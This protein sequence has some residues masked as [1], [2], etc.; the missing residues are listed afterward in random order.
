MH[1][2]ESDMIE[3]QLF[4]D[5]ETPTLGLLISK[6][7]DHAPVEVTAVFDSGLAKIITVPA[8]LAESL[9]LTLLGMVVEQF[10]ESWAPQCVLAEANVSF[11]DQEKMVPVVVTHPFGRVVIGPGFLQRFKLRLIVD[12]QGTAL[13]EDAEWRRAEKALADWPTREPSDAPDAPWIARVLAESQPKNTNTLN[14]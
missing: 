9:G 12:H 5:S 11:L 14:K 8:D 2:E 4:D 6:S 1:K 7:E 10:A 13:V 3:T